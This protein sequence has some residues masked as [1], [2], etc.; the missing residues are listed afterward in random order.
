MPHPL[1]RWLMRATLIMVATATSGFA[2]ETLHVYGPGGPLPAMK[3]AAA[4]FGKQHGIDVVVTGG[5]TRT[6]IESAKNDGDLIY[7]GS[8][9]MMTEF[10]DALADQIDPSTAL[11]LYLRPSSVLVRPGNPKEIRGLRDLG[12][13]GV[14]I[15]VVQGAGQT[16]MWE[17]MVGRTGDIDLLRAVRNNIRV[18]APDSGKARQAWT[19]DKRLDAWLIWNI[20]QVSNPDLAQTVPVEEEFVIYRDTGIAYTQRGKNKPA[21]RQF[22]EYLQS[23]QG[24]RIFAKWGWMTP[25][26]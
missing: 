21:A 24:A 1:F 6:W 11:P 10:I 22:V 13:P 16:G 3:E 4:S 18:F 25:A 14:N 5:P 20:W 12:K 19:S 7:S 8:E 2:A 9:H 17:D 23:P 15:L 26:R